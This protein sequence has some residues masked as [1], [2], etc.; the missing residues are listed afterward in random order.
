MSH[1]VHRCHLKVLNPRPFHAESQSL[2]S[3]ETLGLM[4]PDSNIQ[5]NLLLPSTTP[6]IECLRI[7]HDKPPL[8][9][10]PT[11]L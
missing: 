11:N 8:L 10:V 1:A 9:I 4:V 2:K 7:H 5:L 6:D 3:D